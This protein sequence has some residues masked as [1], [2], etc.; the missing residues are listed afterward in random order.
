[1]DMQRVCNATVGNKCLLIQGVNSGAILLGSVTPLFVFKLLPGTFAPCCLFFS[2]RIP[3]P[4]FLPLVLHTL[5]AY[6]T[7]LRSIYRK[8]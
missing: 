3:L 8:L 1:M 7:S 2:L 4:L 5:S 6:K